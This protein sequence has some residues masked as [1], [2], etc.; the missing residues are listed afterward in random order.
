MMATKKKKTDLLASAVQGIGLT[1]GSIVHAV[2]DAIH[3]S[4][5]A[6]KKKAAKR[7]IAPVAKKKAPAKKKVAAKKK[8]RGQG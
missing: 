4:R 8:E 7:K 6:A 3:P 2:S 5:P 1:L